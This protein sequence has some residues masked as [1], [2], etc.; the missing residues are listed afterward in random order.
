VIGWILRPLFVRHRRAFLTSAAAAAALGVALYGLLGDAQ[1]VEDHRPL[2][3]TPVVRIAPVDVVRNDLI[4]QVTLAPTDVRAWVKLA[5]MELAD[6]RFRDAA[7]AY[8]KALAASP[9]AAAD[10]GLRCE[11][12][13]AVALAQGGSFAGQPR[14]IVM[15]ALA[16]D[17]AHPK[18]LQMAGTV[19]FDERD[20][21]SAG[22]YW[23]TLAAQLPPGSAEQ[24][25]AS[26]AVARAELMADARR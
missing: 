11:Y 2:D 21:D 5:R 23:R 6:D 16:R 3:T 22:R 18:A 15:D 19:A 25:E 13:D 9:E 24:R 14:E 20:Y 10:V 26:A 4:A 8:A 1:A 17:P 12:A 7:D